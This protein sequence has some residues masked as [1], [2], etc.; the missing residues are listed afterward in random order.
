MA[1][2]ANSGRRDLSPGPGRLP[3]KFTLKL[4]DTFGISEKTADGKFVPMVLATVVE[5]NR[6]CLVLET[7]EHNRITIFR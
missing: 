6:K 1:G 7:S 4:G 2:N 5:V 3:K